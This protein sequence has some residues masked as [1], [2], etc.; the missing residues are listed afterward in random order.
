LTGSASLESGT[1]QFV[2]GANG[3]PEPST[4]ALVLLAALL[5]ARRRSTVHA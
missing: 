4:L 1:V 3:I 5:L 2:T